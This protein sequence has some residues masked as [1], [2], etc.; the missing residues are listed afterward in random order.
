MPETASFFWSRIFQTETLPKKL[1]RWQCGL[2]V[3]FVVLMSV[4]LAT[5]QDAEQADAPEVEQTPQPSLALRTLRVVGSRSPD[6]SAEDSPVPV[7]IIDGDNFKNYGVRDLNNL[8]AAT[9]PSYNVTQH[10]IGDAN[11]LV[12]PAK[13]R[14]LPPDSTLVL[15]NG[16][17]RHRSSAIS[18]FTFG[19]AQGAHGVDIRSIPSIALKRVEVLRDGAGA[20]YG[21][22][23]VAGVLNFVLR[24]EPEG[25]TVEARWGQYYQGDGD[26]VST[27]ANVGLPLTDAGFANFS[28]EFTNSDSTDRSY[29]L[30]S[31][32]SL[33]AAGLPV[34]NPAMIWGAPDVPYDYK[35]F[36]NLGLDLGDHHHAYAFGNW[37]EREILD[38]WYFRSPTAHYGSPAS[39]G[40]V[41][42]DGGNVLVADLS[43][44]G[45]SGNCPTIPSSELAQN[46]VAA[47]APLHG[48]PNCYALAQNLPGGF[49]P[50][51][52][53]NVEDWGFTFGLRGE[54]RSKYAL[55][56]GWN[57]D[58]SAVFG[59]HR[60]T[61][62]VWNT[63]N[64]QLLRLREDMPT[65][66]FG[67][68]YE[69]RDMIFNLDLSRRFDT[70]LFYSPLNVAFGLEY[71]EEEYEIEAGEKNGWCIDDQGECDGQPKEHGL[72]AQ[73]F[74]VGGQAYPGI[75]PE[76]AAEANRGSFGAYL[77]LEADVIEQVLVTAAGRFEHHEGIGESVD[78][79]LAARWSLLEDYLAL[80]G[81]LGTGFRAPTVGQAIYR[82]T[83]FGLD[84]DGILTEQPTLPASDPIAQQKGARP[85]TPETSFSFSI[86]TV[87]TLGELS[88]TLDYYNIEV[89]NRIGLTAPQSIT[90][91]DK[92]ALAARGVATRVTTV[93][94]FTNAFETYT[95]G[96]DLVATYPLRLFGDRYGT[97]LLTF[98]GNWND[99]KLNLD[100]INSQ[101]IDSVRKVQVEEIEPEFRFSLMADHTW[102]AWRGLLRL[103]YYDQF[104]E[105]YQDYFT[106]PSLRPKA[107]ALLDLEASYTF[108]FGMTVAVGAEN[109]LDTY[110]TKVGRLH[111][112]AYDAGQ[113]YPVASPYGYNGGFY[114]FR[115]GFEWY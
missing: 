8:L 60:T 102:G 88:V 65:E 7:D 99:T 24:D 93:N 76:N 73:G 58:M 20:Q 71:R 70:G 79:K 92:A 55:F 95:Q 74:D 97:T 85:L 103:H 3:S 104:T 29:A 30:D 77:D 100:S 57:Y 54:L 45:R 4:P 28:F 51:M 62:F 39:I 67:R 90:A 69:E 12:R 111:R 63:V 81:S 94:F 72:A 1:G 33:R 41:Y 48:N 9:I 98:A 83:T 13:L 66:Y 50:R 89:R 86:G 115:A 2:V 26:A 38:S 105:P 37:A 107:R 114:Y 112:D 42:E 5:A 14:G 34:K 110:P 53:G 109:L 96:V 61:Y 40:G 49:T 80:R 101:V 91:E 82:D 11:A 106:S 108:D 68:A 87:L 15:V 75:R 6:R 21:S 84:A 17:R 31:E 43:P 25:G 78:G 32:N 23:A 47:L 10:A 64:P 22:D 16:K 44:D 36:G 113:K 52:R 56:D 19:Q 59:Q 35:F 46:G 27:A 18:I